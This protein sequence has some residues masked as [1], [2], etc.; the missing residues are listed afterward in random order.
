M[1][2][3][4]HKP[5]LD[6][7]RGLAVIIVMAHHAYIPYFRGGELGVDIFFVLSGFLITRLLVEEWEHKSTISLSRFYFRRALRLLPALAVFLLFM[8]NSW[9]IFLENP[10]GNRCCTPVFSQLDEGA[11]AC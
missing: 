5:C 2:R 6:G 11:T 8:A 9:R 1:P 3:M 10:A 7:L 4:G